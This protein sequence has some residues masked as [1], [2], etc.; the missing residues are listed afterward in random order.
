MSHHSAKVLITNICGALGY[1]FCLALW[2]WTGVLYV[3]MLLQNER[4]EQLLIPSSDQPATAPE[5]PVSPSPITTVLAVAITVAVLI[6]TIVIILRAPK[7]I[8]VAGKSVTTKA[9]DA[10]LPLIAKHQKLTP[11]KKQ[12]LTAQLIKLIKLLLV[13]LP[14]IIGCIGAFVELPLSFSLAMFVSGVLAICALLLF[15]VQYIAA[16]VLGVDS[17]LLI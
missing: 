17:K 6:I 15:S 3:P 7:T 12:R 5:A 11:A 10:A 14:V 13:V 4:I 8:A 1:M 2:G 9:A 16:H